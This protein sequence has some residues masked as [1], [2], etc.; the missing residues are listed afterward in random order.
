VWSPDG[1]RIA[2]G[3]NP[4]PAGQQP[5]AD[6][7]GGT[8]N[9]FEKRADGT[10]DPTLLL[11]SAAAKLPLGWKQPTSWSPDGQLIVFEML[12][13]KTSWD[14]WALRLTGDRKPQPLIRTEFQEAEGQI[15]SDGRWLAY[16][17]NETRRLEI[18][19]RPLSGASG[20]W[21]ISTTGGAYPR[22]RRDGKELFYVSRDRKLMSVP[23]NSSGASIEAGIPHALFDMRLAPQYIT[24]NG[25]NPQA[26]A[27]WPYV[28]SRDGD[29]FL[30]SVDTSQ[31][32][33]ETPLTVVVNWAAGL[34]R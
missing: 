23:V 21:Q 2:F 11:D 27:P 13:P 1:T 7:Y 24:G 9:L 25:L 5:P 22:W 31:Q 30:V 32:T 3:A 26:N 17:S 8:F 16:A 34:K 29:R 14:L 10:G 12:D 15:S 28:V 18:Y 20:K 19:V 4:P 33:S 6:G